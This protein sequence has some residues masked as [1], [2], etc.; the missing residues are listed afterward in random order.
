ME[1]MVLAKGEIEN[2]ARL[3]PGGFCVHTQFFLHC[4]F[5]KNIAS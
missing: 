4:I 2:Q 5:A 1:N 3:I